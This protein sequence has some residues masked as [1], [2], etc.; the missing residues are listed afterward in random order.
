M[1]AIPI[2]TDIKARLF[3]PAAKIINDKTAAKTKITPPIV[4]V[5]LL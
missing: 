2:A 3:F 5:P 4:G 1:Y